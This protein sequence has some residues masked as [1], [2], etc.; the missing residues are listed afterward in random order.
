MKILEARTPARWI[1]AAVGSLVC[2]SPALAQDASPVTGTDQIEDIVVTAQRREERLQD[3]PLAVTAVTGDALARQGVTDTRSLMVSVPALDYTQQN[4][5]ALI[6]LRGVG[7]ANA[8]M[9]QE[10][11]V[12]VYVD[13]VYLSSPTGSL[14]SFNNIE[15]IEVLKGPQGTLFGRN[16][17]GGVVQ[18]VTK[19]P[20]AD[21]KLDAKVGY[22]NFDTWEGSLYATTGLGADLSADI[23]L[24]AKKQNDGWGTNVETGEDAFD[25]QNDFSVR[26]KWLWTPGDRTEVRLAV[27]YSRSRSETG[28]AWNVLPGTFGI[29][30]TTT[31]VGFYNIAHNFPSASVVKQAG[32]T[33]TVN[34]EM[35]WA[36]LVSISAYRWLDGRFTLDQDATPRRQVDAIVDQKA[37]TLS[38][39][40][41]L[42]SAP[43][44]A[45]K[46]IVGLYFNRDKPEFNPLHVE[47]L[48]T[49]SFPYIDINSYQLSYSYAAFGQATVDLG[50]QTRATGGIRFTRDERHVVGTRIAAPSTYL[51]DVDKR[52]NFEKVTWRL[53]LDHEIVPDVMV[54]AS[55]NRG[56]KSGTFNLSSLLDPAVKPE[57]LDA[58]EIGYKTEL[59]GRRLRLN[60][61]FFYYDYKNIQTS[62]VLS[63]GGQ[64]IVNAPGATIKGFDVDLTAVPVPGLTVQAGLGYTH[65]RYKDFPNAP[66]FT[67]AAAGA[68]QGTVNA[69]GNATVHTPEITVNASATYSFDT[70]IGGFDVTGSYAYNDGFFWYPDN[71]TTQPSYHIVNASIGWRSTN[72]AFGVTFWGKNLAKEKYYAFVSESGLGFAGSPAAP[73]T[74]GVTFGVKY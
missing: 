1:G 35:D 9:G 61:S 16:A 21:T 58:Y 20:S 65:G 59:A 33:L 5:G 67:P 70:A 15:R 45:L 48:A 73:R 10:S 31:N 7:T 41:Q 52:A 11:S 69:R 32:A 29:D 42:V 74:Y 13:G 2:A 24:Y 38:Q 30:G 17:T 47:G 36:S 64:R 63:T 54:Y 12:A 60:G 53:A 18:I 4:N 55:Y 44:S 34:H 26:S 3:V 39:E 43:E 14:F 23:A 51:A 28:V 62:Q 66:L 71:V 40:L 57:V 19:D 25:N 56:F 46:W 49:G 37:T 8:G 22:G 68:V 6:Y 72:D 50:P 27:D